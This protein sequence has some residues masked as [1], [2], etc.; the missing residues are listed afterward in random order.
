[1]AGLIFWLCVGMILYSYAG[2]P[3]LVRQQTS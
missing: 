3:L 1:M 2:Y